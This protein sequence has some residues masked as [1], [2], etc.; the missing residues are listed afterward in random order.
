MEDANGGLSVPEGYI[1]TVGQKKKKQPTT[2]K[3]EE[4]E[5]LERKTLEQ[6]GCACLHQWLSIYQKKK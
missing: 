6:Y 5:V 3:D 4:W 2:M 1:P